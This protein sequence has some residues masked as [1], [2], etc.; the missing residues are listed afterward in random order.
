[1]QKEMGREL[2]IGSDTIL[3]LKS[4]A[5]SLAL[6]LQGPELITDIPFH[7]LPLYKARLIGAPEVA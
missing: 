5:F 2:G 6:T 7:L 1:M 3:P 4:G